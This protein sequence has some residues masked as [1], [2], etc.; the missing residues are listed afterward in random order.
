MLLDAM[1]P[2]LSVEHSTVVS[3][4][5]SIATS[6]DVYVIPFDGAT[7]IP[8]QVAQND[9]I[10]FAYEWYLEGELV[11][12][13]PNV[14]LQNGNL[15][16]SSVRAEQRGEYECVVKLSVSGLGGVFLRETVGSVTIGVGGEGGKGREGG[17]KGGGEAGKGGRGREGEFRSMFS[18]PQ[19]SHTSHLLPSVPPSPLPPPTPS[20]STGHNRWTLATFLFRATLSKSFSLATQSVPRQIQNGT[21][22]SLWTTLQLLKL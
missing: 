21:S 12:Y 1:L 5:N 10:S 11:V 22:T 4:P 19:R 13:G 6:N 14:E 16:L 8:C 15:T 7:T 20:P 18:L 3:A 2:C 9:G 17:R